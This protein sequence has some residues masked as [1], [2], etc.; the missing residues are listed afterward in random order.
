VIHVAPLSRLAAVAGSLPAYHLLTLLSPGSD[1]AM[2]RT[3]A[4]AQR[5]HLSFHDIADTRAGL[6][7][8]D[9][10]TI[11]TI[12]DFARAV[13]GDIPVLIHCWAGISRS[14]AAA[15]IIACDGNPGREDEIADALRR[16]AP[17]VTPNPLMVRLADELLERSGRMS[18]A[19]TRIGR[20]AEAFEGAPYRLP[21]VY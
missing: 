8:P 15:Y 14:S 7:A 17:F 2:L 1:G 9:R 21:R 5:L 10:S 3:L 12:L 11:V 4:P 13:P 20:G 6:I 19:I 16:L 18:A